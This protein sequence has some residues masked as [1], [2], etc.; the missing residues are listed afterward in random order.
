MAGKERTLGPK[1]VVLADDHTLVLEAF[2]QLLSSEVDVVGT[3]TD[4]HELIRQARKLKPDIVITEISLPKLNGFDACSKL[5]KTLP[6]T[7]IIFLT[8]NEDPDLVAEVM[9]WGAKG[10]VL[11]S[12]S[13][14]ELIEAIRAVAAGGTYISPLVAKGMVDSL[15]TGG[16]HDLY[17]KLT[18]RQ[19]EILQLLA[20]GKTMKETARILS[21]TPRTVAFHKYRIMDSLG[22]ENNADLFKF[23]MKS[24]LLDA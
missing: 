15:I 7:K 19:R 20:E 8:I 9:R 12:S 13:S 4:G 22:V 11:K 16:K 10:Y 23:A 2:S 18:A 3:A 5:L 17:E 1:R 24:A 6:E 14:S 21:I